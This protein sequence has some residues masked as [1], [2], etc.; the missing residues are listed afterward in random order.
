M[1]VTTDITSNLA[2]R[3]KIVKT[4]TSD[5]GYL[6]STNA[7]P[8]YRKSTAVDTVI[9][10]PIQK[11]GNNMVFNLLVSPASSAG[12][13]QIDVLHP[14]A[15]QGGYSW[16]ERPVT[17]MS[18]SSNAWESFISTSPIGA[19][20]TESAGFVFGPIDV[21]LYGLNFGTTSSGIIGD[22]QYFV[23]LMIGESTGASAASHAALST[24][25]ENI[26]V[27]AIEVPQ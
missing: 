14:P 7:Y 2:V 22:L 3:E 16:G 11:P 26:Q 8:G 10:F 24:C 21:A 19:T 23:A 18:T 27:S 17:Y 9:R 25:V 4:S 12:Y 20:S 5:V 15:S 1:V 13:V 6:I